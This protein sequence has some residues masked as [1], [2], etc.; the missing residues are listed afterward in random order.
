M[1]KKSMKR[2]WILTGFSA[3]VFIVVFVFAI[4]GLADSVKEMTEMTIAK[5]PDTILA[6][7]GVVEDKDTLLSVVY[8]DQREDECVNIYDL[9]ATSELKNR[10]FGWSGCGYERKQIEKGLVEKNLDED[11]TLVWR[12]GDLL[13]NKAEDISRWF[14]A[15]DGK[16]KS[17]VGTLRLENNSE[18]REYSY[19]AEEFYPLDDASFSLGD[20]SSADGHN[21]LFTMNFAVPFTTARNGEEEFS[22]T[23]DDDTFV[24]VGDELAI[25]MGGIHEAM[26]GK[27]KIDRNGKVYAAV[28]DEEL[29]D[30]G[31]RIDGGS[32]LRV[33]HA[34]RDTTESV[35]KIKFSGMNLEVVETKIAG[36]ENE[37]QI[38]YDPSDPSY[39]P[40][41]G[42]SATFLPDR[43][44]EYIALATVEG[45]L[46]A[47]LSIL[48]VISI[49]II[50]ERKLHE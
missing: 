37:V 7:S 27:I 16:S 31:I 3:A 18:V 43:T 1:N 48:L 11:Y 50:V 12:G 28:M 29:A 46:V 26:T 10:Q 17:Y 40:P 23:A 15:V 22:I 5:I 42:E 9:Q 6:S 34:D 8:F 33:Y 38:A 44:R 20:G 36:G 19:E 14:K 4:V 24:F 30:S 35:F 47:A 49:R 39:I 13:P 41:L 2:L 25:D 45:A 32:I 21:H